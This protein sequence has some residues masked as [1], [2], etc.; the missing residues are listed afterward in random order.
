MKGPFT[1]DDARRHGLELWHLRGANW[2]RL[3]AATY[4]W[5][6]LADD[7]MD[8]LRAAL[9]R[10]PSGAAFSGMTAVWLHGI[11]V[12]PSATIEV[13]V[14]PDARVSARS[15]MSLHRCTLAKDDIVRANG[16][17]VIRV[18]RTLADV[19]RRFTV[20]EAVVLVDSALFRRRTRLS[21][22]QSWIASRSGA[23]GIL[24]LRRAV[25]FAEP[26]SESPMESRL[27]MLL[28]LGGL[29]RPRAQ[30]SIHDRWA[31]FVGRLDLYYEDARLGIEYDG[32]THRDSMAA[33]NRR[34][35]KLLNAGVRLLRFT[36]SD[37]LG[38]PDQVVA[39]VRAMLQ[40]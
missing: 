20:T 36:A 39:Q 29:P 26:A 31:R 13:T 35:N 30:V 6:G 10:L 5:T 32:S 24:A 8:R 33:D 19:C 23:H 4:A 11:D 3:G 37:V 21:S 38:S 34:Q 25:G 2:R 15:G 12:T 1:L 40:S 27:R 17:P 16:I 22:L 18:E 14:P 7:P 9:K 28:V